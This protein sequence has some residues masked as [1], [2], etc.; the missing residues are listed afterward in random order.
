MKA[1][2]FLTGVMLIMIG[3]SACKPKEERAPADSDGRFF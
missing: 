1:N 3:F 2:L